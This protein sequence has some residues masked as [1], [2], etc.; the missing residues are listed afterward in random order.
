MQYRE[1]RPERTVLTFDILC[2]NRAAPEAEM[3]HIVVIV[4]VTH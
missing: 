4:W 3:S 1:K 2:G